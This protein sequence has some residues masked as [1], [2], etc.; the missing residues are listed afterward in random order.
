MDSINR[1]NPL[2]RLTI[3]VQILNILYF[4]IDFFFQTCLKL[5]VL[6][7]L[8]TR[9]V[10]DYFFFNIKRFKAIPVF[11][12]TLSYLYTEILYISLEYNFLNHKSGKE[13]RY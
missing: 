9:S 4:L 2:D 12:N 11:N 13:A 7:V 3:K 5:D 10:I 6:L 8:N 1:G